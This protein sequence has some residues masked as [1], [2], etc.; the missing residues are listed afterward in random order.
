MLYQ[1]AMKASASIY[2]LFVTAAL[3]AGIL[4]VHTELE[5]MA[6]HNSYPWLQLT[7]PLEGGEGSESDMSFTTSTMSPEAFTA[8]HSMA[9]LADL[10]FEPGFSTPI[11]P[12]P[13]HDARAHTLSFA[14]EFHLTKKVD[15]GIETTKLDAETQ[16]QYCSLDMLSNNTFSLRQ[17][18]VKEADGFT[19]FDA[20]ET[21]GYYEQN[22][23]DQ[24]ADFTFLDA[25]ENCEHY[26]RV[27]DS[28]E[29]LLSRKMFGPSS[30]S[31]SRCGNGP[32][33]EP[34]ESIIE[35]LP[36][37]REKSIP[38]DLNET[39]IDDGDG[40]P[41]PSMIESDDSSVEDIGLRKAFACPYFRLDP[42]R[43]IEC[44]SRRLYRIQDIKQHL[45]RRH[46]IRRDK[47]S[48]ASDNIQGIN[49]KTQ[50]ILKLRSDRRLSPESQ[51]RE[52]WRTLFDRSLPRE[53]P[54]LGNLKEEIVGSAITICKKGSSRV[55]PGI[56]RSLGLRNDQGK[57]IQQLMEHLFSG[58][59]AL[60]KEESNDV[61]TEDTSTY[62]GVDSLPLTPKGMDFGFDVPLHRSPS[63]QIQA[64]YSTEDIMQIEQFSSV[65]PTRLP[66]DTT[67]ERNN[68]NDI[69]MEYQ[70]TK[71][72]KTDVQVKPVWS[73]HTA[74]GTLKTVENSET[75]CST[76]NSKP[77]G[78]SLNCWTPVL[79]D[80]KDADIGMYEY[81]DAWECDNCGFEY[82]FRPS[83]TSSDMLCFNVLC[84]GRLPGHYDSVYKARVRRGG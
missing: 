33:F 4:I 34:L 58:F 28:T 46:Y 63:P 44:L 10:E 49:I 35:D 50:K 73:L 52:I 77:D 24:V 2:T 26:G 30:T 17:L 59:Q 7:Q 82:I 66:D 75:A 12:F 8:Q 61:E 67:F 11:P 32:N 76:S 37:F 19:S 57:A 62:S 18:S 16:P 14:E 47:M 64:S 3:F 78:K 31:M 80:R 79:D 56:V 54:Y 1:T 70:P 29:S 65:M 48:N 6:G 55:V 53:G 45:S 22:P 15:N 51:W 5:L 25:S 21:N 23:V 81:V 60:S 27:Q 69:L 68:E 84:L 74:L 42:V 9:S 41:C 71:H 83:G 13:S 39:C 40:S 43:H 20:S 72:L 36:S 38:L